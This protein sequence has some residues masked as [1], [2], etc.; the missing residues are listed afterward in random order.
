MLAGGQS[1]MPL[2]NFRLE[3]ARRAR[4]PEPR[5][6]SLAYIRE[7]DGHV[8]LGAM[9]RQR[10]IEFSPVVRAAPAAAGRGDRA[11]RASADPHARDHR[12]QPRPRRSLRRV[13]GGRWRRS[14]ARWS[15]RG[16]ARRAHADAP[17]SCSRAISPRASA[18]TRCSSRCGCPRCRP[19]PASPSRSSAGATATS[20]SSGSPAMV[21]GAGRRGARRRASATAGAGPVPTRLRAAE[22]ILE[23]DGLVDAA[24]EAAA[25]ARRRARRPR[26]RHARLRRLPPPPDPRADRPRAPPRGRAHGG[27]LTMAEPVA[28]RAHRQ[29]PGAR[30][31]LR[32]AQAPGGFPARG[33]RPHRHPRRLRA[34][35]S[36]AP[37]PSSSTARPP[38]RA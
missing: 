18:P 37:A 6:R 19:A 11:G 38:A 21:V 24:I 17:A 23:R 34:R 7:D 3:P 13:P 22:E 9:T 27:A 31:P 8:R 33:P 5:S 36:A 1:L 28:V 20:P 32:A 26:R 35:R 10:T 15:S 29:R 12:R 4:R 30:G 25:R 2:L 16:P 14:T